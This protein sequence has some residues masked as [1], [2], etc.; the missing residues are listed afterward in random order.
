VEKNLKLTCEV[1]VGAEKTALIKF[2]AQHWLR[3]LRSLF[4]VVLMALGFF[5][6]AHAC[7][8]VVSDGGNNIN[9]GSGNLLLKR[10]SGFGDVVYRK[11]VKIDFTSCNTVTSINFQGNNAFIKQVAN[12]TDFTLQI[13]TNSSTPFE[14][15]CLGILA[16]NCS[17]SPA[18]VGLNIEHLISSAGITGNGCSVTSS[19]SQ[20][21]RLLSSSALTFS[22]SSSCTQRVVI[23]TVLM[24]RSNTTVDALQFGDIIK[25]NYMTTSLLSG[26]SV[27]A[28]VDATTQFGIPKKFTYLT[29]TCSINMPSIIDLG[30]VTLDTVNKATPGGQVGTWQNMPISLNNCSTDAVQSFDKLF[31]WTF[32]K[33]APDA[34]SMLNDGGSATGVS[35]QIR[36]NTSL[37]NADGST[38]S[39]GII[40]SG[41]TYEGPLKGSTAISPTY[42]VGFIRNS[43][44][45][46]S[47]SFSSNAILSLDYR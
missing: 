38:N 42:S 8:P 32:A 33:P 45:V 46:G 35:A 44:A 31:T 40:N 37:K 43:D 17:P 5:G 47:G 14:P 4:C 6:S 10:S 9:A 34:L 25:H 22:I 11:S 28:I 13:G 30:A 39:S 36:V 29:P 26:Q 1:A 12:K 19:G 15:I 7:S 27:I 16:S 41:L 24:K 21:Q 2:I 23:S 18:A 3:W 20:G